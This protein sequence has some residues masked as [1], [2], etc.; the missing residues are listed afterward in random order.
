MGIREKHRR[1]KRPFGSPEWVANALHKK[2]TGADDHDPEEIAT[3]SDYLNYRKL[4]GILWPRRQA[5]GKV[6]WVDPPNYS[7]R[8]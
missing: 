6:V 7:N 5:P 3:M 1:T 4:H 2:F 8:V